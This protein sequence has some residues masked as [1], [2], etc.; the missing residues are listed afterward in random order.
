MHSRSNDSCPV[1]LRV[2]VGLSG[3]S[4]HP[5]NLNSKIE[6]SKGSTQCNKSFVIMASAKNVRTVAC[7]RFLQLDINH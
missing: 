2:C 5:S 1:C 7:L 4:F 3:R 6:V